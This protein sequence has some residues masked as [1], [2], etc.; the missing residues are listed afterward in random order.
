MNEISQILRLE[1]QFSLSLLPRK[2]EQKGKMTSMELSNHILCVIIIAVINKMTHKHETVNFVRKSL[3]HVGSESSSRFLCILKTCVIKMEWNLHVSF[4]AVVQCIQWVMVM[5][6]KYD[7]VGMKFINF[8]LS[9]NK[10]HAVPHW[11]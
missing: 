9:R 1:Q 10:N 8:E 4:N 5:D 7:S 2:S 6:G 11:F 3:W